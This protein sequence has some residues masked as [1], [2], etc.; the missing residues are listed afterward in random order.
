MSPWLFN[1][2][3]GWCMVDLRKWSKSDGG[4]WLTMGV[5]VG[6]VCG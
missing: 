5:V 1:I 4:G 2:Y 6:S 3:R